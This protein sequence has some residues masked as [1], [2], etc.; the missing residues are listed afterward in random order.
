VIYLLVF[1][2]VGVAGGGSSICRGIGSDGS[3]LSATLD[4][5]SASCIASLAFASACSASNLALTAASLAAAAIVLGVACPG[6]GMSPVLAF[7]LP[8]LTVVFLVLFLQ[9]KK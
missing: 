1:G 9:P 8:A 5:S 2:P 3:T 6:V 4:A 7:F